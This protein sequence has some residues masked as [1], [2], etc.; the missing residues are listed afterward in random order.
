MEYFV[1]WARLDGSE[2]GMDDEPY[3]SREEAEKG[4]EKLKADDAENGEAGEWEYRVEERDSDQSE[5]EDEEWGMEFEAGD[6]PDE[7]SVVCAT[8]GGG[9]SVRR[10]ATS[11]E[12]EMWEIGMRE[13]DFC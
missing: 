3:E 1:F 11:Y 10:F 12:R 7:R 9:L 5:R 2:E 13:S 4:I 8:A 6:H